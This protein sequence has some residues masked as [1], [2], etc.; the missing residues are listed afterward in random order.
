MDNNN[1]N[2]KFEYNFNIINQIIDLLIEYKKDNDYNFLIKIKNII[3][4]NT[5][6]KFDY[7]NYIKINRPMFFEF[8]KKDIKLWCKIVHRLYEIK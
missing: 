2:K 4:D 5:N 1:M 6:D 8:S 3:G 7:N